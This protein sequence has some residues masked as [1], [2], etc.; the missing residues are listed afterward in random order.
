MLTSRDEWLRQVE[1]EA[2]AQARDQRERDTLRE[3]VFNG[4]HAPQQLS[5]LPAMTFRV[6]Q[7][8]FRLDE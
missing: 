6:N 5:Q 3:D 8:D 4:D 2:E 1:A 7:S